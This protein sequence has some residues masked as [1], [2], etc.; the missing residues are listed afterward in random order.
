VNRSA[1]TAY[2]I[3]RVEAVSLPLGNEIA[4]AIVITIQE[5][6]SRRLVNAKAL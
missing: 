2:L 3:N 4:L 6:R 5:L 1:E